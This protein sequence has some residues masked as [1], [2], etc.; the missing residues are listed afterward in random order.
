MAQKLITEHPLR[1]NVTDEVNF[2]S[3]DGIQSYR[4][5]APQVKEYVLADEN[6]GRSAIAAAE[7]IPVGCIMPFAGSV[8][9]TGWLL[10]YG[11]AVSRTTYADLFAALGTTFGLGDGTTTFNLP[12]LRGRVI[13]GKDN[14]GGS[15]AN[16]ITSAAVSIDGATLGASGGAQTHTLNSSQMPSHSHTQNAHSHE[17][18]TFFNAAPGGTS[19]TGIGN[20]TYAGSAIAAAANTATNQNTGGGGAHNNVQPTIIMNQIIKY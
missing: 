14:M 8:S 18:Q 15:A 3:D 20:T 13:A 4:V 12:D 19:V 5:T 6:V 9:P 2:I 11:Q 16:R 17:P 10:C 1:D 7:R